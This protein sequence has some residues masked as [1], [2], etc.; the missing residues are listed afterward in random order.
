MERGHITFFPAEGVGDTCGANIVNGRYSLTKFAPGRKRVLVTVH[1]E[2]EFRTK[3]GAR[4]VAMR[5][6]QPIPMDAVGNYQIFDID[7]NL[8]VLDIALS[9]PPSQQ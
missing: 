3:G 6:Y 5:P 2:V 8:H 1:P 9:K 7:A 4:T